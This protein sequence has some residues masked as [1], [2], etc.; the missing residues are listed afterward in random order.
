MRSALSRHD[1][2]A[3]LPPLWRATC[4]WGPFGANPPFLQRT[5]VHMSITELCDELGALARL[6]GRL[7]DLAAARRLADGA[8]RFFNN[9]LLYPECSGGDGDAASRCGCVFSLPLCNARRAFIG[10]CHNHKPSARNG[11]VVLCGRHSL[12]STRGR[13]PPLR[14]P[15]RS[16]RMRPASCCAAAAGWP[17]ICSCRPSPSSSCAAALPS[18]SHSAWQRCL[19]TAAVPARQRRAPAGWRQC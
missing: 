5:R 18:S 1:G 10:T 4:A 14:L 3:A 2:R 6:G 8:E 9:V 12:P 17:L 13:R 16:R 15:W 11:P 19:P 7:S